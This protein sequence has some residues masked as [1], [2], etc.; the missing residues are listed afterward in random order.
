MVALLLLHERLTM[1]DWCSSPVLYSRA[2]A[3]RFVAQQLRDLFESLVFRGFPAVKSLSHERLLAGVVVA[4]PASTHLMVAL[5]VQPTPASWPYVKCTW[6]PPIM[7]SFSSPVGR[8]LRVIRS[9]LLRR[10]FLIAAF[11]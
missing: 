8:G 9:L 10:L 2:A 6:H 4:G 5:T 3:V 7:M 1:P 11:G